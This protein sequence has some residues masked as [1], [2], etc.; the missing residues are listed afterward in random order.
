MLECGLDCSTV[1]L[2]LVERIT[3][4]KCLFLCVTSADPKLVDR[5]QYNLMLRFSNAKSRWC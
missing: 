2:V 4:K 1:F 5:L 3:I